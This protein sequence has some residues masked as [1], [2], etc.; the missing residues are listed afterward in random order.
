MTKLSDDDLN[1]RDRDL[2]QKLMRY[3]DLNIFRDKD[4]ILIDNKVGLVQ[5][6]YDFVLPEEM[7]QFN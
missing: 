7:K 6:L 4:G 5:D 2:C 3:I 1:T